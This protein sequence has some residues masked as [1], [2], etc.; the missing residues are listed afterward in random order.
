MSDP[1]TEE[2][3]SSAHASQE[4]PLK[5][6]DEE[7]ED[8]DSKEDLVDGSTSNAT[9][10]SHSPT[11]EELLQS[12]E[13]SSSHLEGFLCPSENG[14][15]TITGSAFEQHQ[16][17]LQFTTD[18][19]QSLLTPLFFFRIVSLTSGSFSL[20]NQLWRGGS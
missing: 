5:F 14:Y 4:D 2:T 19:H 6:E 15:F 3:T 1:V 13:A 11:P 16:K 9:I 10:P 8:N 20:T 12:S 17:Y 7:E 18:R